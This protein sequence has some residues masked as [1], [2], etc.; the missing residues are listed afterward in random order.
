MSQT[1]CCPAGSLP[2]IRRMDNSKNLRHEKPTACLNGPTIR[3]TRTYFSGGGGGS[4]EWSQEQP[5]DSE[6][7]AL[8]AVSHLQARA[9]K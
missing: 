6:R 3:L 8:Q 7:G 1:I 2:S 4:G 9:G 5:M